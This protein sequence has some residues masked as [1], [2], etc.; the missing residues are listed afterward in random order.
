MANR[1][2][3]DTANVSAPSL[4]RGWISATFA[5]GIALFLVETVL[6]AVL[7]RKLIMVGSLTSLGS[8]GFL[9]L[10]SLWCLTAA[11][12]GL[13]FPRT[14][15][16]ARGV[17]IGAA[18]VVVFLVAVMT[19]VIGKG[20]YDSASTP[21][22]RLEPGNGRPEFVVRLGSA[23]ES[24]RLSLYQ[25]SGKQF[26][27]VDAVELPLPDAQKFRAEHRLEKA[28]NGTVVLAYPRM[29]GST[30]RVVLPRS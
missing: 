30:A 26:D 27:L 24:D 13:L 8:T 25:G 14:G 29:D 6:T 7:Q 9:Y 2:V 4:R 21:L 10:A 5:I 3:S 17:R 23:V 1:S 22:F 12:L 18:I 16:I 20:A 11:L 19:N 15:S 28:A